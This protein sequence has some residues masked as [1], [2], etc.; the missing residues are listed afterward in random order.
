MGAPTE[1]PFQID[2]RI[3]P[4]GRLNFLDLESAIEIYTPM[5]Q[6]FLT[7]SDFLRARNSLQLD[8]PVA[9]YT[10]RLIGDAS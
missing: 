3:L 7:D 9:I 8:E 5:Y 6:L 2:Q 4:A 10:S 1:G